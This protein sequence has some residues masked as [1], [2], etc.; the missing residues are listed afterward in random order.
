MVTNE[1]I[2]GVRIGKFYIGENVDILKKK[3]SGRVDIEKGSQSIVLKTENMS[4][5]IDKRTNKVFQIGV[6][7]NFKGKFLDRIGLGSTLLDVQK[8]IGEWEEEFDVYILPK[9]PGI[10]FEL[11]D[12][13]DYEEEWNESEMPINAIYIYDQNYFDEK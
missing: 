9:Y 7:N 10:C 2:P 8:S 1:I 5:W 11:K 3:L 13:D 4:F 6:T 12:I